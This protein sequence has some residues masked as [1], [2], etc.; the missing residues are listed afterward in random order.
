MQH[1]FLQSCSATP[2]A[3]NRS[4]RSRRTR[5]AEEERRQATKTARALGTGHALRTDKPDGGKQRGRRGSEPRPRTDAPRHAQGPSRRPTRSSSSA[6]RR[7]PPPSPA[8]RHLHELAALCLALRRLGTIPLRLR[9][10]SL[11]LRLRSL[12]LR[13]RSL[14]LRFVLRRGRGGVR[15][16]H[17]NAHV[18][19]RR[20]ERV[21]RTRERARGAAGRSRWPAAGD[22]RTRCARLR[23][24]RHLA[25]I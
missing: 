20:V 13:L 6:I 14:R 16:S 11:R 18:H 22:R 23:A 8:P 9:L 10:R 1:L 12:R 5:I 3:K 24:G 25:H 21:H 17:G 15:H 19:Q 2:A 4:G 7:K